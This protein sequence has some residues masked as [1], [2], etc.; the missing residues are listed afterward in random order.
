MQTAFPLTCGR[1]DERATGIELASGPNS[2]F[3][4]EDANKTRK[5]PHFH[6]WQAFDPPSRLYISRY[7]SSSR[8]TDGD[9]T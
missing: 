1:I 4:P 7:T 2:S 5:T 3:Q 9:A 8:A 6:R